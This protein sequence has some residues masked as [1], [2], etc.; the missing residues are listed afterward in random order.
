MKIQIDS[1]GL[2]KIYGA[3][4]T[5]T[6]AR[7]VGRIVEAVAAQSL[8]ATAAQPTVAWQAF[9]PAQTNSVGWTDQY[10][11]FAT[12]TPLI[13]GAV[14]KM[15]AQYASPMQIG[16]IYRFTEGQFVEQQ[17]AG[18]SYV[19]S[20]AMSSGS[21]AFGMAQSATVNDVTAL[22]PICAV[23]VLFN[24]AVYFSPNDLIAIFLSSSQC[25]GTVIP[26]PAGVFTTAVKPGDT[27]TTVGFNDQ[28]N[29]F[30]LIA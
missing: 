3:S 28:T 18:S 2:S 23:P 19:I 24:E 8:G 15:N 25:G 29:M 10:Y 16:A 13:I 7:Q 12:T 30:F 5:V 26:P 9:A 4:Q 14:I 1:A 6:L 21:Y 11:C 17:Q 20:N 22:A 27:G